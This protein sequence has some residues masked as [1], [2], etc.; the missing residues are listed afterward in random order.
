MTGPRRKAQGE[1]SAEARA[2][3]AEMED[4]VRRMLALDPARRISPAEA[5]TH[6][7]ITHLDG[8]RT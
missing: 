5:L 7:F 6:P 4:L 3:Y 2:A 8:L 1:E